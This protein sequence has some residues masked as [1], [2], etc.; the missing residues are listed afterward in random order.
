M[1]QLIQLF[2]HT[3]HRQAHKWDIGDDGL[4]DYDGVF[5]TPQEAYEDFKINFTMFNILC[6]EVCE[7]INIENS[8]RPYKWITLERLDK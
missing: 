6:A 3:S 8:E 4:V 1:E 5:L 2:I 7:R